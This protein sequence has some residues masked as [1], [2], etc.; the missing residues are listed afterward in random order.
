MEKGR[1]QNHE[2]LQQPLFHIR[3]IGRIA[4]GREKVQFSVWKELTFK[5][6]N[7]IILFRE[8]MALS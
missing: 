2:V 3:T 8:N 1:L 4:A 6:K 7:D 5:L